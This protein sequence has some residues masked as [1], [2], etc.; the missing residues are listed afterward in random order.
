[1]NYEYLRGPHRGNDALLSVA[2]QIYAPIFEALSERHAKL[3][4]FGSKDGPLCD[5]SCCLAVNSVDEPIL[6]QYG[7][8]RTGGYVGFNHGSGLVRPHAYFTLKDCPDIVLDPT[9]G[10]YANDI[11]KSVNDWIDKA[12]E[13]FFRHILTGSKTEISSKLGLIY[14]QENISFSDFFLNGMRT[15]L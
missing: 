11:G 10:Q 14:P 8:M 6:N 15:V 9:C 2:S 1:M 5:R 7:L 12:S 13:L 4:A 3:G